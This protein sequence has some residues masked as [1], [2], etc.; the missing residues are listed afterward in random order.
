MRSFVEDFVSILKSN[1]AI[2]VFSLMKTMII[3]RYLGPELNGLVTAILVYPT[4]FMAIGSLGIRQS[5]TFLLGSGKYSEAEVKKGVLQLWILTSICSLLL[6]YFLIRYTAKTDYSLQLVCLAV[7]PVPFSLLNTYISGI[8]LGKNEIRAF[9]Q[10]TWL[11]P[12]VTLISVFVLVVLMGSGINGVLVAELTGVLMMAI[13]LTLRLNLFRC[14]SL[15]IDISLV[16]TLLVLGISY[17]ASLFVI[18]LNYRVD[19]VILERLSTPYEIGIYSK[20]AALGQYLWH[21]P[22]LLSTI[23]FA[24]GARAKD[25]TLY[26]LKVAQLLRVSLAI[27][28][29]GCIALA[30]FA[31]WIIWFLFGDQFLPSVSVMVL[32]LPGVFLLTI[33]KVLVMDMAGRG[34]P[35]FT[36]RS[37]IPALIVNVVLNIVLVPQFG[38]NGAALASTVSYAL[39]AAFF[40]VQYSSATGISLKDIFGFSRGDYAFAVPYLDKLRQLVKL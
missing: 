5:S 22:M 34:R 38:A 10:V 25:R 4:M 31:R 18:N 28:L 39:G 30:A 11:P 12:L 35:L 24:R 27:V 29:L 1:V 23:V 16:R 21:I 6:I 19:V 33:F 40:V 17:A 13:V 36:L 20:G 9:N 2:I 8:Y 7:A 37:M 26:S 32:L 3:A 15:H 14:F